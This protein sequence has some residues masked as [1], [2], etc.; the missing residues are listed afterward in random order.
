MSQDKR[1]DLRDILDELDRV[2]D[3]FERS[4]EDTVR[5]S[6]NAGQKVFSRPVVAGMAMG[7]GPEGKPTINFF[8]DRLTGAD[9]YRTPIYEKVIDEKEGKL[10]LLFELPGVE[11]EDIQISALPDRVS[12]VAAKGD[13]KYKTEVT[14]ERE[15]DPESGTASYK[16]GLLESIFTL[17]DKTN[18]GYR[19]ITVV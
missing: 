3:E 18:K 1:R 2:F 17:R 5:S 14:L 4:V 6:L 11:K 12:L 13:R 8:G 9:G 19:G 16:N 7:V 15:I 10:R